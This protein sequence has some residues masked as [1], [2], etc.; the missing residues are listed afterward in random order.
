MRIKKKDKEELDVTS[1]EDEE[2]TKQV[3]VAMPAQEVVEDLE[4]CQSEATT[5]VR[6]ID[7][8]E[9]IQFAEDELEVQC[10]WETFLQTRNDMLV[11]GEMQEIAG[12]IDSCNANSEPSRL[13]GTGPGY[14]DTAC[15]RHMT[16]EKDLLIG[17]LQPNATKLECANGKILASGGIGSV[18][19]SCM[20]ENRNPLTTRVDD[21]LYSP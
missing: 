16:N 13:H 20:D 21:V 10:I 2:V 8:E 17:K 1:N 14:L 3:W 9:A 11:S 5:R 12:Y 18:R 19:L 15:S 6:D 7:V 4:F